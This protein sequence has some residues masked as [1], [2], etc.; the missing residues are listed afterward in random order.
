MSLRIGHFADLHVRGL[1]RHDEIRTVISAF[2]EDAKQRKLDHIVF[3]GDFWHTKTSGL[4]PEA[5]DLMTWIFR[6]MAAIAK[7]HVTLGNHDGALTNFTRQDAISP[8]IT[9]IAD[10][11]IVLY[12]QSGVYQMEPGVNLCVYSLFDREGWD[13]VEAI[14]GEYNIAVYHGSVGGAVSEDGWLLKSEVTVQ[15]F[16][17]KK[18]DLVLLGDIHKQQ[19]LGYRD[20]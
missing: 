4:T 13:A 7:V 1:T 11:N 20:C 8:I 18:F 5:V 10:L 12:K 16:E 17:D 19:Y 2:C 3:A 6:S 15:W 9:A 14:E